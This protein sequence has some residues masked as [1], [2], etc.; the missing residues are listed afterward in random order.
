MDGTALLL[1]GL[2]GAGKT[3]TAVLLRKTLVPSVEVSN[4][5]VRYMARPHDF[6]S[7]TI[8]ASELACVEFA[9]SYLESGFTP[10]IDGV[11][12]DLDFLEVQRLR[13]RRRGFRLITVTLRGTLKDLL[14][15]NA[16]RD[17]LT[18]M[19]E[20]RVRDLHK[21][22]RPSGI[23]LDIAGKRPEEVA[24]EVMKLLEEPP[25]AATGTRP[26]VEVLFLRH[27]APDH[28]PGVHPDHFAMGLSAAGRAEALAARAAVERFAPDA[29]YASDFGRTYETAVLAAGPSGPDVQR[30]PAL[31]ERVFHSLA[32][33]P[34]DRTPG[35]DDRY[36]PAGEE[37]YEEARRRVL[38]FFAG[39]TDR[40]DGR[41]VLV[42][43]HGGPHAWL[44]EKALRAD[45]KGVRRLRLDTGHFS[46]FHLHGDTVSVEFL[47]RPPDDVGREPD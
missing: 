18:R 4:D 8:R 47:N 5:S 21:E 7:F 25:A 37:T 27:G 2:P 42:V 30:C 24:G 36:E 31:R 10:V 6:T 38:G 39:L 23:T 35:D 14:A 43:A 41:R 15:R 32:G 46:R 29:V 3:T 17:P 44:L 12:H 26:G 16:V 11:F 13:F 20:H 28:P 19:R 22:F 33:S 34:L 45:L 9:L 40:H 1:R